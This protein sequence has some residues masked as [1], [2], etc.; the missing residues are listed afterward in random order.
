MKF[1]PL[2]KIK[3]AISLETSG[4][5]LA[6]QYAY[7]HYSLLTSIQLL[8]FI[9]VYVSLLNKSKNHFK[10]TPFI[11]WWGCKHTNVPIHALYIF[12]F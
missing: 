9:L 2:Y 3:I 7:L 5:L 1:G 10:F 12:K 6:L 8:Q 11:Y 4:R